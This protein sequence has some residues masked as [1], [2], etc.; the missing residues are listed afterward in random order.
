MVQ[1]KSQRQV[2][3]LGLVGQSH[4]REALQRSAKLQTHHPISCLRKIEDPSVTCSLQF[5][6]V[7]EQGFDP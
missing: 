5:D 4:T 3:Q 2:E 6:R 7:D 1:G